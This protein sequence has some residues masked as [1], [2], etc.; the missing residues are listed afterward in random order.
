M[1]GIDRS[2]T[3]KYISFLENTYLVFSLSKY[4]PLIRETL[5][6]QPKI[7]LIDQGFAPIFATPENSIYESVVARHLFALYPRQFYFWRDRTEVDLILKF[8]DNLV[9]IEVKNTTNISLK[10][11]SGLS[12]FCTKYRCKTA[13]VLY[14]GPTRTDTLGNTTLHFLPTWDFLLDHDKDQFVIIED[15][16]A[17]IK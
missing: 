15:P 6:S 7:H 12:T 5:R 9:P 3:S 14:N 11:L 16:K 2:Q 4:S 17:V 8:P 13:Y 1:L 10:E